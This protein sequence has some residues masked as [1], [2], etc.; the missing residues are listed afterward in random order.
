[1]ILPEE[2][3]SNRIYDRLAADYG[4]AYDTTYTQFL[5]YD[6]VRRFAKSTDICLDVGIGN[7][8]DAI[9]LVQLVK[10]IHGI[11]IS[12]NML[13]EC[14]KNLQDAGLSNVYMYEC[15][16][17]HLLFDDEFFDL[18]FSFST[19]VLVPQPERAYKEI[20]RVLKPGGMAILDITG[21]YNLSQVYWRRWYRKQGHHTLNAYSLHEIR[22]TFI[23]LGFDV[24]ETH[25]SGLLDQWKY[26]PGLNLFGFLDK[27]FHRTKHEPDLDYKISQIFPALANRWYFVLR[28]S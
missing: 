26:L 24:I 11:D 9:P 18:V 19:L 20:A 14:Q 7:G 12:P 16:A 28:K 8:I 25:A 5:K 17:T 13:A 2:L 3:T 6:L 23:D 1:M 15:S 22:R 10:E 21:K 4:L 27:V